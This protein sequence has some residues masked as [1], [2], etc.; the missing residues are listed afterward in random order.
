MEKVEEQDSYSHILKYTGIFG[1]VQ[2]L[3]I[4]IGIARNKFAAILLGANGMGLVSLF[5]STINM[6]VSATNF[7]IPTSGVQVI[8]SK[9]QSQSDQLAGSIKSIRSWSLLTALL[10]TLVCVLF[11]SFLDKLTFTW[12]NHVLHFVLLSPVVGLTILAAGEMA[13][14][15]ATRQLK[16]LASSSLLVI[17]S[18][19]VISVPVY[20]VWNQKGII[21]VLVFQALGQCLAT[22]YFSLRYYP[23]SVSFSIPFLRKGIGVIKLGVAFVLAGLLNSGAEFLI[24]TY[25]NNVGGLDHVGFFN[26]GWTLAVVYSGLVFSSMDADYFPR[27]SSVTGAITEQ[28]DCVNKQIEMNVLLVSPILTVM[29]IGLPIGIPILYDSDFMTILRMTQLALVSMLFKAIYIPIEYLP[30]S[31]G[32]SWIFLC[33]EAAC[34]LLL[35]VSQIV[36][37]HYM[38]LDGLGLGILVAYFVETMCVLLYSK[39]YFTFQ[40]SRQVFFAILPQALFLSVA[41]VWIFMDVPVWCYWLVGA[42]LAVGHLSYA[43]RQLRNKT[44]VQNVFARK[45]RK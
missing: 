13:V 22:F 6:L 30:L 14:L 10:G 43:F 31:K 15:K 29:L 9:Y 37:Y 21:A 28:N 11:S 12:G 39:F 19:L 40:L 4:L 16:S 18:S 44:N 33:Q 3:N 42:I 26:A 7:G 25:I 34:V 41:V 1:G 20:Y 8:S 24:R 27:L 5:S 35:I 32:K 36:G 45:L 23:Y 38:G 17:A 2:G